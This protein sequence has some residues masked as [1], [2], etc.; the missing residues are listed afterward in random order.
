MRL[1]ILSD[2]HVEF[3]PFEPEPTPADVVVL[4]GDIHLGREG[5]KWARRYFPDKPV[6]YVLGNHEFYRN[7][8]PELTNKLKEETAGSHIHVLEND[9]LELNGFSILGCTLWTD[10]HLWPDP[11]AAMLVADQG[12]SD[13]AL[14]EMKAEKRIF[15]PW[16]SAKLHAESVA[17]LKKELAV[18]DPA[19][20][21]VVTHHAPSGQSIAPR[22]AGSVLNAAFASKLDSFIEHSRVPLW[23]HGHTHHNVDYTIG[24]TRVYTNQRG[25]PSYALEGFRPGAIVEV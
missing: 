24:S 21:I 25:Y 18:R 20:T 14:I 8:I 1:H 4:A 17:W 2:L 5:R 23:I 10:F 16:D 12:M 15:R 6:V 9:V 22:Y 19:Q 7:S 3:G 13:F 11:E